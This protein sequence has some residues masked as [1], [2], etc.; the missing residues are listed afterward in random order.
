[1]YLFPLT[2]SGSFYCGEHMQEASL[3]KPHTFHGGCAHIMQSSSIRGSTGT[4]DWTLFVVG[5]ISFF[6][7]FTEVQMYF[8]SLSKTLL[9]A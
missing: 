5:L 2:A 6:V 7:F 3:R 8:H 4:D 9:P 1:M